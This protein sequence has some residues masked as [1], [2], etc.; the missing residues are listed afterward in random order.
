MD[1]DWENKL[2]EKELPNIKYF[3]STLTNTKCSQ[4]DYEQAQE[5]FKYFKCKNIE[6][7][8]N[9]YVQSDALL[10]S[11]SIT[12]Y[13]TKGYNSFGIDPIHCVSAP[14]F[15]NKAMLKFTKAK[16]HLITDPN[17]LFTIIRGI[18][19]GECQ[20]IY[21]H[22]IANNI[23]VNPNFNEKTDTPSFNISLDANALN[24]SCMTEKLQMENGFM[25]RILKN[26]LLN[27][28]Y[29]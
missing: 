25:I 12:A 13:T 23:Y 6:D 15:T 4:K 11:A 9:I 8:N 28:F 3:N 29:L 5:T 21:H 1:K 2:K 22:G 27:I 20:V 7:Y 10:L 19:G 16:I 26:I 24:A 17:M 14:S 18:R